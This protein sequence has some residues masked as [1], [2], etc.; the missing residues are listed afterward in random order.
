MS[1]DSGEINSQLNDSSIPDISMIE[2][3]IN[4]NLNYFQHQDIYMKISLAEELIMIAC[5]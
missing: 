3:D 5:F 1:H 2:N 4:L